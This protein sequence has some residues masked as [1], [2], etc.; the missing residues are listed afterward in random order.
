M[1][2]VTWGRGREVLNLVEG[3]L[4]DAQAVFVFGTTEASSTTAR[5]DSGGPVF[6][7]VPT[8]VRSFLVGL[9]LGANFYG[10]RTDNDPNSPVDNNAFSVISSDRVRFP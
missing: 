1:R 6:A 8:G 10:N 3:I 4:K 2:E 5:G 7:L 9:T